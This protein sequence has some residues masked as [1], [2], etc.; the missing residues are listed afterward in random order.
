MASAQIMQV[1]EIVGLT[2]PTDYL[3]GTPED[4]KYK[5]TVFL[6]CDRSSTDHVMG[7]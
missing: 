5:G 1:E 4:G 7:G 3:L 2:G 6:V